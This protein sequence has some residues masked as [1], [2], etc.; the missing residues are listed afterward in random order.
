MLREFVEWNHYKFA[1]KASDW[2]EAVRMSCETLEAD[3]TVE[4]N[5]KE[6]IIE[7]V[8]KY[9]P[10]IVIMPNVAMPHSQECARGVHK[11]AIGFM[12]LKKPVSFVPGDTEKDARLFFTLASSNPEQ[13]L[14]NMTKLS[15]LLMN[16]AA[17]EA[18]LEA[19]T[20]EDL[21]RIQ[22]NYLDE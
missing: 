15:E 9:G 8:K 2:Q 7:C 11:T 10:Y 12:R 4:A 5:Y 13:H 19:E 6:D 1:E 14:Q 20:P 18:L 21:L 17:V 22:E 3:G 16:E